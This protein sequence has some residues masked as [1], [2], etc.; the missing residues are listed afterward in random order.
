MPAIDIANPIVKLCMG[1]TQAEFEGRIESARELYRKAWKASTN[2]YEACIAAHYMARHQDSADETLR[3]NREA[4]HRANAVGD[5]SVAEFYPSL[6][7]NMGH[8]YELV[9]NPAEAKKFFDLAAEL[10]VAHQT[11]FVPTHRAG[12][13]PLRQGT[14][15][16]SR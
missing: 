2:D 8:S 10:G 4:L 6:Y 16:R 11:D 5:D 1:G 15:K 14:V 13:Q 7:L 9:G 3:W 12:T